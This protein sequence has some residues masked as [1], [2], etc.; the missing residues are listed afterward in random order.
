MANQPLQTRIALKYDTYENWTKNQPEGSTVGKNL[1]LLKGE[2][3]I[4]EIPSTNADST[5][6]PTV[7][8]KVGDGEKKFY[9]LPWAS[10][11][12]ADVYS[13]AKS[14]TV[15]LTEKT[16]TIGEA[17]VT[18]QY[19]EFKTNND[20]NYSVDLSSFATDNELAAVASR[21][22][23]IEDAL[24]LSDGAEGTIT[25]Q[26][27]DINDRLDEITGV[28]NGD[29]THTDGLIDEAEARI[30][31]KLGT[32]FGTGEG[33]KTV[34]KTIEDAQSAA[35]QHA[36][37]AIAA[38]SEEGG[39]IFS[40]AAR[41]G[42]IEDQLD[43]IGSSTVVNYVTDAINNLDSTNDG[44]VTG[45]A[46]NANTIVKSVSQTD[47]KVTVTY[48]K[49]T[50]AEL[51]TLAEEDIPEIHTNK[52]VVADATTDGKGNTIAKVTLDAKLIAIDSDISGIRDAIA[53]GV[54]FR[55]TVAADEDLTDGVVTING[56]SYTADQGDVIIKGTQEYIY[57]GTQWEPLGDVTRIGAVEGRVDE[58]EEAIA[59]MDINFEAEANNFVTGITQVDG[60][61]TA[62][63]TARPTAENVKYGTK[64]VEGT[65]TDVTVKA[66][67]DE[68]A[69]EI[70]AVEDRADKL[71]DKVNLA[72]GETVTGKIADAIQALDFTD[73]QAS[74]EGNFV[75]SVTQTEGQIAVKKGKLP[76]A[77]TTTAGIA[78]LGVSG[79]AATFD[80]VDTLSQNVDD[81]TNNTIPG[82]IDRL[83]DV[84]EDY[85]RIAIDDSNNSKLVQGKDG[86]DMII[87]CCGSST[88]VV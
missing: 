73:S 79:G 64:Y 29:G 61:I 20:V 47:G 50:R 63:D 43:G 78:T 32:G 5:T 60:K 22:Q 12:A 39:A 7:L 74:G 33:E 82:I 11:L 19:L 80:T 16:E 13:W 84:E 14:E 15:V 65:E 59:A 42:A 10:A 38:L 18:K 9:E 52:V 77:N 26:I 28:D 87:F 27:N 46:A 58:I 70:D 17:S 54:H 48:G 25:D 4:C 31:A 37:E 21:V 57:N 30:E 51:P 53:G 44:D 71:E 88:E 24:G 56:Q 68:L 62:I 76:E 41:T 81:I 69:N 35:E 2:I 86:N 49:L 67:I 66:K 3:G 83:D 8:F 75:V 36:D 45:G 34:A 1:V 6:A 55:G 85:V 72:E 40:L 23:A